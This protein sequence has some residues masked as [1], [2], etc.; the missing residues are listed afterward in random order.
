MSMFIE[1]RMMPLSM[2]DTWD[3]S[4]PRAMALLLRK[5]RNGFPGF[6]QLFTKS[7][8]EVGNFFHCK[9]N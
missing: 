8:I 7:G 9:K 3:R 5:L 1:G 6:L 2:R 4:V